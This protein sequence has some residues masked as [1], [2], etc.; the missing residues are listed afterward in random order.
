MPE[1]ICCNY[2]TQSLTYSTTYTT[3]T[4]CHYR[5][6]DYDS[7]HRSADI[8]PPSKSRA[9]KW[10]DCI[11]LAAFFLFPTLFI[12]N[13]D[14]RAARSTVRSRHCTRIGRHNLDVYFSGQ[15]ERW[16]HGGCW[17]ARPEIFVRGGQFLKI[18]RPTLSLRAAINN[19]GRDRARASAYLL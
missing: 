15:R 2:P 10:R 1:T 8:R 3:A 12:F 4:S 18:K 19:N 14:T 16:S 6:R 13:H 11:F 17:P 7:N 9:T 5:H